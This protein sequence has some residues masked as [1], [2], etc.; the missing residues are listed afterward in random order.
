[1]VQMKVEASP[2]DTT[3]VG[4]LGRSHAVKWSLASESAGRLDNPMGTKIKT[5]SQQQLDLRRGPVSQRTTSVE[6]LNHRASW[7]MALRNIKGN[8]MPGLPDS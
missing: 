7:G 1:M 4:V 3:H 2:S 5:E 6:C 8:G